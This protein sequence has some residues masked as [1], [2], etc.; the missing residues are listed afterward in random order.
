MTKRVVNL[1]NLKSLKF[2]NAG[3]EALITADVISGKRLY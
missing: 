2:S 3:L 1:D